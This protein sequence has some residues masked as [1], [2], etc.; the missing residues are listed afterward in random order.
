MDSTLRPNGTA[1]LDTPDGIL[2]YY[3]SEEAGQ[4]YTPPLEIETTTNIR[5]KVHRKMSVA[6]SPSE[7]SPNTDEEPD[8]KSF[9]SPATATPATAKKQRPF[10]SA[11]T[12]A[13]L[14]SRPSLPSVG[15]SDRRR[16]AM[17]SS[18]HGH[19]SV[20]STST[21]RHN[22]IRSR[23]G[24]ERPMELVA[25]P[26]AS[27]KSYTQLTPP[28]TAPLSAN[29]GNPNASTISHHRSFSDITNSGGASTNS[30]SS[31]STGHRRKPSRQVS[32]VGTN[33]GTSILPSPIL[34]QAK[35]HQSPDL[36]H[37]P[38]FQLPQSRSSSPAMSQSDISD[39]RGSSSMSVHPP[40][41]LVV[42]PDIGEGK[43]TRDALIT[44]PTSPQTARPSRRSPSPTKLSARASSPGGESTSTTASSSGSSYPSPPFSPE[45]PPSSFLYYQPGVHATA[46]PLPP[47]PRAA[48]NIV[49]GTTP[50]PRPPRLNSPPPKNRSRGN[51]GS[52]SQA[53]QLPGSGASSLSGKTSNGSLSDVRSNS[54]KSVMSDHSEIIQSRCCTI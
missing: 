49:P 52:V 14:R 23:R 36:M 54:S 41:P 38:I 9:Q 51:V 26:D 33:D 10:A 37:A 45:L 1:R 11:P 25:P 30:S 24:I 2:S 12:S 48:F 31:N 5:P 50:P 20:D 53:L 22:S 29:W 16:L 4:L 46:G 32:I 7:Y 42:T 40:Y 39:S 27:P 43:N 6:S 34:E 28:A 19:G 17:S 8:P 35:Q 13:G 18:E 15:G 47:P 21:T 3:Q 44:T